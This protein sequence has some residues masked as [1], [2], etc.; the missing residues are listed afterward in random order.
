SL[1]IL[2]LSLL[3]GFPHLSAAQQIG[4]NCAEPQPWCPRQKSQTQAQQPLKPLREQ[5][6]VHAE[7][8]QSRS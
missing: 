5:H 3:L 2:F 6:R 7:V 8:V 4:M 1:R